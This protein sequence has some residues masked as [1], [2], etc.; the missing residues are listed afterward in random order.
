[1]YPD[2]QPYG[3]PVPE[4]VTQGP[5]GWTLCDSKS[6]VGDRGWGTWNSWMWIID[7]AE[8]P[9][10]DVE[11]FVHDWDRSRAEDWSL[12]DQPGDQNRTGTATY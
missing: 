11:A 5:A 4:S 9:D 7:Q 12:G 1:M 6:L 3:L 8:R 2:I 10:F